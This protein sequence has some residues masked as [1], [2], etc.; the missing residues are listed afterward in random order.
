M[1]RRSHGLR[2]G[3]RK[4][5]RKNPRQRGH[6]TITRRLQTFEKGDRVAIVIEPAFQKGMPHM[7]F[8]GLTGIVRSTL[9]RAYVVD[10]PIGKSKKT[11]ISHPVHLKRLE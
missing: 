6:I 3:T 5:F 1:A 2:H 9:G 7:R 8:Q 4:V 10:V 11:V